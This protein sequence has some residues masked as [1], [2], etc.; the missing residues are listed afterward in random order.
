MP[1][2]VNKRTHQ[3]PSIYVGRGSLWGNPFII[4]KDGD[5]AEVIMKHAAWL[6][7]QEHLLKALPSLAGHD[8]CCWCSPRPCHGD[9]L[10]W[11]ANMELLERQKIFREFIV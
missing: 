5:R 3:G 6:F 4:G 8:L 1:L 11:L 9:L 7:E 10:L 2:V